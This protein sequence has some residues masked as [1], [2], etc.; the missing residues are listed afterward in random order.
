M[1]E[2]WESARQCIRKAQKKQKANYDKISRPPN[3]QV[4]DR[5]FLYK[6]AD[7]TG[8]L[9]KF[10]RPYH[11]PF[12][13]VEMDV[14]TAK[15]RRA[16]KPEEDTILVAVIASGNAHQKSLTHSGDHQN[17]ERRRQIRCRLEMEGRLLRTRMDVPP[18][19]ITSSDSDQEAPQQNGL[20]CQTNRTNG[21]K[22]MTGSRRKE[23][24]PRLSASDKTRQAMRRSEL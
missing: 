24:Q 14:N 22:E 5:V 4:R 10:A 6:P 12:R 19:E 1:I 11:G 20:S 13:V 21:P 17:S 16:D 7:K 18:G 9:R 2:A 8:P 23:N 3:F 15:I